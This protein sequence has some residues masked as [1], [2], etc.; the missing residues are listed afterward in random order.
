MN[1]KRERIGVA[2]QLVRGVAPL[3]QGWFSRY[4]PFPVRAERHARALVPV[5]FPAM[6]ALVVLVAPKEPLPHV[7]RH[8][9]EPIIADPLW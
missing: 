5:A 4:R 3:I 6:L 9:L 7:L 2:D 1:E 8:G